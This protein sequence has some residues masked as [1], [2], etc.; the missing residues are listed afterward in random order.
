MTPE[1]PRRVAA[2]L[3]GTTLLML[4]VVGS[5]I[6]MGDDGAAGLFHHAAVVGGTLVA[7][8]VT[9]APVSGAHFN[10]AVTLAFAADGDLDRR[11]VL[12]FVIAQVTGAVLGAVLAN[13]IF[14]EPLVA[15]AATDRGGV[16]R[17]VSEGLATGGLVLVV[18]GSVRARRDAHVPYVVGAWIMGAIVFTS[19]ASFANPAV[20]VGRAFTGTWTGIRAGHVPGFVLGQA[21]GTVG[22]VLLGRWLFRNAD[23]APLDGVDPAVSHGA[24]APRL[25]EPT[26]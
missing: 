22:A 21:V 11:E 25:R 5:G 3:V 16:A 26:S 9:F 12:P 6:T 20:T 1:T 23:P 4:A 14:G 18:F 13:A 17:I 15:T 7:L 10:P 24:D 19:S 8:I 2:E